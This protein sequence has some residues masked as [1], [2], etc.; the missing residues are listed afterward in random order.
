[1]EDDNRIIQLSTDEA[2]ETQMARTLFYF[3]KEK[4]DNPSQK[5]KEEM[6]DVF[7]NHMLTQTTD[8][9]QGE[10]KYEDRSPPAK[11]EALRQVMG[12][13]TSRA[14]C[15]IDGIQNRTDRRDRERAQLFLTMT[16]ALCEATSTL[17]GATPSIAKSNV[18]ALPLK[19]LIAAFE[20]EED[21]P[22]Y[23]QT[24]L[25]SLLERVLLRFKNKKWHP[26]LCMAARNFASQIEEII[27]EEESIRLRIN[28]RPQ[29]HVQRSL[30]RF[31]RSI[32]KYMSGKRYM[33]I[34][35]KSR[36]DLIN[37][38]GFNVREAALYL[39]LLRTNAEMRKFKSQDEQD[40]VA[41]MRFSDGHW[42]QKGTTVEVQDIYFNWHFRRVLRVV[43]SSDGDGKL[44]GLVNK[45]YTVPLET[46]GSTTN[47]TKQEYF[48]PVTGLNSTNPGT[49]KNERTS[50]RD[51]KDLP[52]GIRI[53]LIEAKNDN[54]VCAYLPPI[55][56]FRLQMKLGYLIPCAD[57]RYI[58]IWIGDGAQAQRSNLAA[59]GFGNRTIVSWTCVAN[60]HMVSSEQYH[61]TVFVATA[62]DSEALW[63]EHGSP[64]AQEMD[65]DFKKFAREHE[66]AVHLN[67]CMW[68]M[69]TAGDLKWLCIVA[70]IL[71]GAPQDIHRPFSPH[72]T[73]LYSL[74]RAWEEINVHRRVS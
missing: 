13:V 39:P 1:M 9:S 66:T 4:C 2:I 32:R 31:L 3:M 54:G 57:G 36:Q 43:R 40:L 73:G 41:S 33:Y 23:A 34:F 35:K 18:G 70:G 58:L 59:T 6:I 47:E 30:Q 12:M 25:K 53:K 65:R 42:I 19:D 67:R 62:S 5:Q 69:W 37:F 44:I 8:T 17:T 51:K 11:S 49:L 7:L 64:F 56:V 24:K 48:T 26:S 16:I 38:F 10:S 55:L 20:D 27:Q 71:K 74:F 52:K 28:R 61:P 21:D 50:D 68:E 15:L 60:V 22:R 29:Q 63:D 46:S 72:H 45:V 14:R